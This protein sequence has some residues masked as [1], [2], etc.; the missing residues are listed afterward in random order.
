MPHRH[1]SHV[2]ISQRRIQV[3]TRRIAVVLIALVSIMMF[4]VS[5]YAVTVQSKEG[6]GEYLA[7]DSG[8]TLYWFKK[9]TTGTSACMNECVALWPLY[10]V[11]KV[12]VPAGL[13][14]KEFGS[15]KRVDGKMQTTFRGYPLYYFVKDKA[16]GDTNGQGVKDVWYVVDPK[17]FMKK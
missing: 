16:K 12:V 5:A 9:D 14:G 3:I 8:M 17:K 13:D 2:N 11:E 6:V 4:T 10:S 15:I 1:V 7:D